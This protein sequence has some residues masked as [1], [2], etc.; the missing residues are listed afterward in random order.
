MRVSP[1]DSRS[2]RARLL[3]RRGL[4]F[5]VPVATA[6][7]IAGHPPDPA[8]ATDLGDAT[9]RYIGIH[10]ALLFMLPLLGIALWLLLDGISGLA[11]TVARILIPVALVFYAAFDALVGIAAGVLSR[12]TTAM[13][14]AER[15]GAEALAAR[16]LEIPTPLP[17]VST[18]AVV[19]WTAALL[20]AALSHY[21]AR[22][23]RVAVAGLALA[24]PLFGFGH[25]YITGV[26]G[27][28]GLLV[29]AL[30]IELNRS[31]RRGLV[32][33]TREGG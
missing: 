8:T 17:I 26:I 23:P 29:A 33:S 7:V 3:V 20:A 25:P 1:P 14:G 10:V 12:E 9:S 31:P 18:L 15:L 30:A 5:A 19:S 21:H 6:A 2:S 4:L 27:M 28:A 13:S 32:L 16:W 24:G 11:A 22:S